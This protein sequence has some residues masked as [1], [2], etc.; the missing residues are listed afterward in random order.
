MKE[1]FENLIRWHFFQNVD[2]P[3]TKP[4]EA[5]EKETECV[6]NGALSGPIVDEPV[7]TDT[8]I[9][10]QL[11]QEVDN[12]VPLN[13]PPSYE[14]GIFYIDIPIYNGAVG[15]VPLSPPPSYEEGILYISKRPFDEAA[16]NV[17]TP[18][19]QYR[20]SVSCI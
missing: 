18:P 1:T 10:M 20:D 6:I 11:D 5:A 9:D 14:D 16:D 12:G 2:G 17:P 7:L 15:N 19:P 3:D 13:P 4:N 8:V